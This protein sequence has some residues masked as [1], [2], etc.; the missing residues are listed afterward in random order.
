[1]TLRIAPTLSRRLLIAAG[2]AAAAGAGARLAVREPPA[3]ARI[4]DVM[5]RHFG[6]KVAASPPAQQFAAEV[7]GRL[8]TALAGL[9]GD[10]LNS[11]LEQQVVAG[12]LHSTTYLSHVSRGEDLFYFG[13]YDPYERPCS[14]QLAAPV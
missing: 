13:F 12:F 4:T 6:T 14:S 10:A 5:K 9:K 11:A 7:E 8:S 1:M 3:A 2:L